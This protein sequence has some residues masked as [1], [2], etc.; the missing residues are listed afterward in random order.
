MPKAKEEEK[1]DVNNLSKTILSNL[2]DEA[3]GDVWNRAEKVLTK[4][5]TGSLRL[6]AEISLTQGIH[7]FCGP[8]GAGKT[9]EAA[10]VARNFLIKYPKGKVLWIKA[11]GRLSEN[12]QNRSGVKFVTNEADWNYGTAFILECNVFEV[13]TNALDTLMNAFYANKER[14]LV[15][16]DS[17]DGVRLKSDEKNDLGKERTAGVPLMLK[18]YLQRSFF[19][20]ENSGTM[21]IVISQVSASPRSEDYSAPPLTPGAGG[22]AALHWS[23][24]ILEFGARY[25]GDNILEDTNKKFDAEKNK[26]VGHYSTVTIKK[27]DKE[28][29][30]K[31][32]QYP[33]KHGRA[34]GRSIW[35]E[36][37]ILE[38][39]EAWGLLNVGGAWYSFPAEIIKDVK[40]KLKFDL[41]PKFQ[42]KGK[43]IKYLEENTKLTQYLFD[44]IKTVVSK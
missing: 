3:K 26:I 40:D 11:E 28:N 9:S 13:L 16:L 12:I 29:E 32:I 17:L 37:E 23:N 21:I 31:K 7:R 2:I 41:E 39:A 18:R 24:Y 14:L 20:I 44:R 42:G 25:W 35:I 30:N 15:V 38:F 5:S 19:L 33:I 36:E 43:I 27:T 10:E 34:D 6:D 22:N 8:A 1:I 4:V